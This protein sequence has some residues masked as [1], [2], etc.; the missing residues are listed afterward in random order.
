MQQITTIAR[1][2]AILALGAALAACVGTAGGAQPTPVAPS[3]DA[4]RADEI[5]TN[6]F[7]ALNSG[8]YAT[9]SR[10][11]SDTMKGAIDA[12][13]FRQFR[14]GVAANVGAYVSHGRP[15]LSSTKPGTFRWTFAVTFERGEASI[16]FAFLDGSTVVDGVFI[17]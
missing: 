4:A 1:A 14:D 2:I 7:A 13:A 5:A 6:A 12:E 8:D 15:V 3:V 9:W 11:W 10:D 17:D 16:A